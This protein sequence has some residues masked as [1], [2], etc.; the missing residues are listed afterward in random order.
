MAKPWLATPIYDWLW[1]EFDWVGHSF[2]NWLFPQCSGTVRLNEEWWPTMP[3][4]WN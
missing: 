3:S 1:C 2:P 4:N